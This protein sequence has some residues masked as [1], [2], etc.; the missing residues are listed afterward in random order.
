[1]TKAEL[2][3]EISSRTGVEKAVAGAV[4]EAFMSGI[5]A[6]VIEHKDVHLRGFGTFT[7][8]HRAAKTGRNISKNVTIDIPERYVPY[9][10]PAKEF[11]DAT[12]GK[13]K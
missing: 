5:K 7:L 1:M 2:I 11:F 12:V 6:R 4:V 10:K 3:A 8:K 13:G 9:F